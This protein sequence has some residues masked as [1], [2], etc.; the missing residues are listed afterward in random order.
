MFILLVF[1]YFVVKYDVSIVEKLV[2]LLLIG[3]VALAPLAWAH[4]RVASAVVQGLFGVYIVLRMHYIRAH[5]KRGVVW[6]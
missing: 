5:E 1:V 6:K 2:L 4:L 3:A